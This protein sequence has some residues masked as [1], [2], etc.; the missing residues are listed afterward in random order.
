MTLIDLFQRFPTEQDCIDYLEKMRWPD[1]KVTCPYCGHKCTGHKRSDGR[2]SCGSCHL[3]FNPITKT[4]FH[5]SRHPLQKWFLLIILMLD[6]KKSISGAQLARNVDIPQPTVWSMS[7]KIRKAMATDQIS[8]LKGITEID[9]HY[10]GGKPRKPNGGTGNS[11]RGRGTSKT[12]IVGAIERGGNVHARVVNNVTKDTLKQFID[13]TIDQKAFIISDNY[14]SYKG[15]VNKQ[16]DH[17]FHFVDDA[18][19]HTNHIESFWAIIKRGIFGQFHSIS[20]KHLN[21]YLAEF[22]YRFN[23]RHVNCCFDETLSRMIFA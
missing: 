9:E 3:A 2:Y 12:P 11:K 4:L 19:W 18:G 23:R 14:R 17:G 15:I 13:E 1:G 8:L 5:K 7:M 6:A 20:K 10:S 22:C 21:S 16:V